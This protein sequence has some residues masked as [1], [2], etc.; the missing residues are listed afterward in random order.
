M[1]LNIKNIKYLNMYIVFSFYKINVRYW[2]AH[3]N[4]E[5]SVPKSRLVS[6]LV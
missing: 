5:L 6:K 3:S 4:D 1:V 2:Q